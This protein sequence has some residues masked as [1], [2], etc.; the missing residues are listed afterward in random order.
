M[1]IKLRQVNSVSG[2]IE[3]PGDKSITH[4]SIMFSS[5][6]EGSSVIRNYLLS[7]DCDRT[8]TAF[9]KVGARIRSDKNNLYI[10]GVGLKLINPTGENYNI[11]AG[12]SGTTARLF[13]GIFSGQNFETIITGDYSL[14][15]RPMQ[16][17]IDPLLE[18]GADIKSNGG[19]LPLV[20][21]GRESLKAI[22]YK[23]EKST[24]QVKS[25]VLLAGLYADGPTTYSE[26]VKSRDHS[27][28]M[29]KIFGVNIDIKGNSVTIYPTDK[30][31]AQDLTIPGDISSAAFFIAAALIVPNS[32]LTIKNVGINPTRN[33]LIEVL[34]QM[35]ANITLINTRE[36]SHE[37]VCDIIIKYSR[38]KAVNIDAS[39]IPR[40]IDE[41]P[42]FTLISTQAEG[43]TKISGAEELKIKETDRIGVVVSQ[44]KKL[45]VQIE[46]L[47]DGFLIDGRNEFALTGGAIV[48][49]FKDHRMAM[50]LA[51]A[52][53]IAKGETVIKNS[54]CVNISFPGFYRMLNSICD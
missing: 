41:I 21:N 11:Y 25:A 38:L 27:E 53:L 44:F 28:R 35:G 51:V 39:I 13:S 46:A 30:L 18:M 33:A 54:D 7:N 29:L 43:V 19:L 45:G 31:I 15:I 5:L 26:P 17:V 16:R 10:K 12:N 20:I 8:I 50:T 47:E 1:E 23:S 2:I 40:M 37:P 9:R 34:K 42:I 48:D 14:S 49:S 24:A 3:V 36:V 32:N 6:S 52:S 22:N 4:R